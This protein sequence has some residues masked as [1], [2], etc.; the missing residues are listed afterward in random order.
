MTKKEIAEYNA[1]KTVGYLKG[2]R[3]GLIIGVIGIT[4]LAIIFMLVN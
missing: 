3:H 2:L 4:A 1:G